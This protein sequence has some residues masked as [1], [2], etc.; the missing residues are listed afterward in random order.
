MP[1]VASDPA[2][3]AFKPTAPLQPRPAPSSDAAPLPF[4]SLLDDSAQAAAPPPQAPLTAPAPAVN[5]SAVADQQDAAPPPATANPAAAKAPQPSG[6]PD[7]TNAVNAAAIDSTLVKP[8]VIDKDGAKANA[9]LGEQAKTDDTSKPVAGGKTD[10]DAKPADAP[11]PVTSAADPTTI[12]VQPTTP[13]TVV[14]ATPASAV[15]AAPAVINIA[16]VAPLGKQ[17]ASA[18]A[19]GGKTDADAKLADAPAPVTLAADPTTV[20]VQPTTPVAVVSATLAP[21]VVVAPAVTDISQ[22]APLGKQLTTAKADTTS[23]PKAK[24]GDLTALQDDADKPASAHPHEE[25]PAVTAH[26]SADK[27]PAAAPDAPAAAPKVAGDILQQ[28]TLPAASADIA[29]TTPITPTAPAASAPAAAQAVAVPIAGVAIEITSQAQAGKNHFEIRLD[30]PEL[31][32]IEVRLDVDRD[33]HVTSRLIADRSDTLNLL[34]SDASG[35]ERALQDAGLKTAENGLQ[36]SLRDQ[37]MGRQQNAAPAAPNS[38]QIV[39]QDSALPAGELTQG[40][41]SRLAGLRGGIDIRV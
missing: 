38:A 5:K 37:T 17:V 8:K 28:A 20:P 1:Q 41:Y 29:P 30:P 9:K 10:A 34:R 4:E 6:N 31:G 11:A 21:A 36:F 12:P 32:R 40:L 33:G 19:A 39:V 3:P 26:A 13:A 14:P 22:I 25:A 7:T 35:L 24:A 15:V 16:Q 18:P 2:A 27:L 23:A